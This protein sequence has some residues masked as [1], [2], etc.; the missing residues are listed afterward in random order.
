MT[1]LTD[2]PILVR[3]REG[4][5]HRSRAVAAMCY[6]LPF[7]LAPLILGSVALYYS[8]KT[9]GNLRDLQAIEAALNDLNDRL[10][11]G[12]P[13]LTPEQRTLLTESIAD[14][15]GTLQSAQA[16]REWHSS[17]L[18]AVGFVTVGVVLLIV[19]VIVFLRLFRPRPQV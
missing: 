3:R 5:R 9:H 15:Q 6:L 12:G 8:V 19:W 1:Y 16:A 14:L 2:G 4:D 7:V 13:A 17:R 18:W 10:I 11:A